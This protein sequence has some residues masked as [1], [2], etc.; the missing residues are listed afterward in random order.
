MEYTKPS[1]I[2]RVVEYLAAAGFGVLVAL[3]GTASYRAYAPLILI[4]VLVAVFSSAIM[5]RAWLGL[6]GL[7]VF[8]LAFL[9]VMQVLSL[10]GPGGDVLMPA[11]A[12]SYTWLV[13]GIVVVGIACFAPKKWFRE[14]EENATE[15]YLPIESQEL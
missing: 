12:L 4:L 6:I 2:L 11:D 5:V 3:L 8:G 9:V 14:D 13:S 10:K 15:T 7:G 1:I